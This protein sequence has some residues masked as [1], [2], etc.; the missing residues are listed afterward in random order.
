LGGNYSKALVYLQWIS[1]KSPLSLHV[2]I[3][4]ILWD[5]NK[6]VPGRAYEYRE[7]LIYPSYRW[8]ELPGGRS[9]QANSLVATVLAGNLITLG[10]QG[11]K[12]NLL[13]MYSFT[14]ECYN[15]SI[16]FN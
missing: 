10:I 12:D 7:K 6:T 1:H 2:S 13:R 4:N 11:W 15:N 3:E 9:N 16:V 14:N 8:R 5:R